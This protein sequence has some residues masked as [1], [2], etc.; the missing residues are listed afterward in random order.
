M[1]VCRPVEN[2]K[3][4]CHGKMAVE[5][6]TFTHILVRSNS[7]CQTDTP[8][9]THSRNGTNRSCTRLDEKIIYIHETEIHKFTKGTNEIYEM[10]TPGAVVVV[11][12]VYT[13]LYLLT[14]RNSW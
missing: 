2:G 11:V 3:N 10:N 6:H 14:S 12:V 7:S 8:T 9:H 13:L 1:W 4:E 5:N